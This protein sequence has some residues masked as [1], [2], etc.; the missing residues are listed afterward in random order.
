MPG[1]AARHDVPREDAAA[2]VCGI[3]PARRDDLDA[4]AAIERA[5]FTD[6]WSR[7]SLAAVLGHPLTRMLVAEDAGHVVG[8][9]IARYVVD[10]A[11]IANLAVDVPYRGRGIAA[12]LLDAAL[13]IGRQLGTT[14][15]FLEVRDSN[16]AARALYAGRG[17]EEIGRRAR[18][19]V[20][21]V[22]DA[23]VMRRTLGGG[24]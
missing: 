9:I 15:I 21:P 2:P 13:D 5:S 4:I 1:D 22:E 6:P 19:Y 24:G 8:Y 18:Y 10:E 12:R 7:A 16:R 3:R 20:H 23:I 11:D 17:F 14:Q